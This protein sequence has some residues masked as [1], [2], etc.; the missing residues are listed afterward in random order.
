MND[1]NN[2]Y[3]Y[4]HIRLDT[5]T[6]FYVGKGKGNRAFLKE[7]KRSKYWNNIVNKYGYKI[8]II[9]KDLTEEQ[10]FAKEI[11]F[12]KLYKSQGFCEANMTD[13][14]TGGDTY[15]HRSDEAKLKF[16]QKISNIQKGKILS[17]ETK[18]KISKSEKGKK[19]SK[20]TR[21]KLSSSLKGR[22]SPN[23]NKKMSENLRIKNSLAQGA[24]LFKMYNIET[25][26]FI[27][28]FTHLFIVVE[29][30]NLQASGI[31]CCLKGRSKSHK[32]FRFEYV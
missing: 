11:E 23:K 4:R 18:R 25:N 30:F 6:P 5:T 9:E 22:I 28:E 26:E 3:V 27:G 29:K 2:F 14:G 24:K 10:A 21:R 17:E 12:I 1:I 20:E 13:G 16:R 19:I 31:C 15:K 8:E 32:G 7:R